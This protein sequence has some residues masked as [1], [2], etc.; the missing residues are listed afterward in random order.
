[1]IA[2]YVPSIVASVGGAMYGIDTGI[3]ATTLSHESFN[4]YMFPPD[5]E[6]LALTG[7]IVSVYNAGQCAGTF[8]GGWAADRFS[9]KRAMTMACAVAIIGITLQVSSVHVG[10]FITGRLTTGLSSGMI[11]P[12]VPVYI[13]ELSKP[14]NRGIIVGFQG[15]GMALGFMAANWIGYA[16]I[17]AEGDLAWRIPLAMQYPCAVFLLIGSNFIPFSP[18]WLMSRGS[19]HEA[20]AVLE[21]LHRGEDASFIDREMAQ[22]QEHL[23]IE[24]AIKSS[25]LFQSFTQLFFRKYIKRTALACFCQ[26]MTELAGVSAIQNFQSIFYA[27]VGFTGDKA[28]LISGIYG[29]MGVIGQIISLTLIA[30]KWKRTTTLWVGCAALAANLAICMALS[31]R[32]SDGSNL[33]ASRATIAFIF[34]YSCVFAA[35]FNSTVYVV[36]AELL[37]TFLRSKGLSLATFLTGVTAIVMTQITPI[38]MDKIGWKYYSIFIATNLVGMCIYKLLL[39]ETQGLTLEEVGVLFGD[40]MPTEELELDKI[41]TQGDLT[42]ERE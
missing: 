19:V 12:V 20:R 10:M 29:F 16:G 30:D 21:K 33:A 32:F 39:P 24:Q 23:T 40:E 1:M 28:L 25:G 6:D 2:Q 3:I 11:L 37:P 38:A 5:G 7:T 42:K 41:A 34:L 26:V 22:M 18:R 13:A 36:S 15:M 14:Q 17:F 35:F 31:A 8:I 27:A 4:I 9:R